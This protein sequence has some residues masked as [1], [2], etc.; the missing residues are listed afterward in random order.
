MFVICTGISGVGKKEYL[1]KL[2]DTDAEKIRLFDVGERMLAVA[3][4]LNI[5]TSTEKVLDM[6]ESTQTALRSTVFEEIIP[7]LQEAVPE[8]HCLISL[9][10]CFRWNK[11]LTLGFNAYHVKRITQIAAEKKIAL[12]YVC[13]TD[14][15]P[16][17]YA[18]LQN[19]P[20]WKD[21]LT[22]EEILLWRDEE[23]A[24][25]EMIA[26]YE[27]TEFYALA[28]EEPLESLWKLVSS[29]HIKKLY[30]SFP[31]TLIKQSPDLLEE[32]GRLRDKLRENF[33][34][35]DP[36]AVKDIEWQIGE[37]SVPAELTGGLT[38]GIPEPT[39]TAKHY[40]ENQTVERDLQLIDQSD[41]VVV[42]Y[43]TDKLSFGVVSEMMHGYTHNKPV[44]AIYPAAVSPFFSY[45]CT[46]IRSS[47]EELL[48]L[49][50]E[51]YPNHRHTTA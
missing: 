29:P 4:H 17:I 15:A 49:L 27:R 37:Y 33:I 19:R 18:R 34:V 12:K 50:Q 6:P 38:G 48:Q 41:F 14:T 26:E 1:A 8:K 31:I 28:S 16:K 36:L 24:L 32:V 13:F 22:L 7:K 20:Q 23:R 47:V 40:M 5:E 2:R 39:D 42:Y 11:F 51:T 9:H 46:A 21:R 35:F 43:K 30:L 44:Y 45:Y 25:T 3:K 10:A